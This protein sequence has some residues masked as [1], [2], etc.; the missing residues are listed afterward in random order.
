MSTNQGAVCGPR[1]PSV[2]GLNVCGWHESEGR[3]LEPSAT[4]MGARFWRPAWK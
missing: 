1:D 2:L 3:E 4:N